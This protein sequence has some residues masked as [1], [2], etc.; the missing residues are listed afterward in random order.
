MALSYRATLTRHLT[1]SALQL[2]RRRRRSDVVAGVVAGLLIG[3][4]GFA[5]WWQLAPPAASVGELAQLRSEHQALRHT[6]E[7][8]QLAERMAEARA[9]ELERQLDTLNQQL[10]GMEDELAFFRKTQGGSKK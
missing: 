10:R 4:I 1:H 2:T 3:A 9:H 8:T 7:Q 6:Q 5:T